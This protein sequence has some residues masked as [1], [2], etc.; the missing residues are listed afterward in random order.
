MSMSIVTLT[1]IH[2]QM[3]YTGR[4]E[5]STLN[6][7][8][9]TSKQGCKDMSTQVIGFPRRRKDPPTK[10]SWTVRQLV[11]IN[12]WIPCW[13]GN[14]VGCLLGAT[15]YIFVHPQEQLRQICVGLSSTRWECLSAIVEPIHKISSWVNPF[16]WYGFL[17][18]CVHRLRLH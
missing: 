4:W 15:I 3:W 8:S 14:S 16:F 5:S 10:P 18:S 9:F 7:H 11:Y 1:C 12:E 2:T 6:H 13:N 17:I